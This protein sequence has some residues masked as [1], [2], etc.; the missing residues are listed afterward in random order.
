MA[1]IIVKYLECAGVDENGDTVFFTRPPEVKFKIIQ[2]T[3]DQQMLKGQTVIS[4]DEY[5]PTKSIY[6]V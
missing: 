2:N 3:E 4:I 6:K 5:E 1:L